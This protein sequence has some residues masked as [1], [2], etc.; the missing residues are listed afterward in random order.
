MVCD[1]TDYGNLNGGDRKLCEVDL[2]R[3][4]QEMNGLNLP[5]WIDEANTI[6]PW[7]IPVDMEQQLILI[8]RT[9]DA[10]KVEE[11]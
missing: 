7:R 11:M 3:G 10:L 5:I 1:G 9:D 4:L 6:D 2:C 8:G